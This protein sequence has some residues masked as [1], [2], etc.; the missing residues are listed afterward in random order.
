MR[1][2][3]LLP[4][5]ETHYPKRYEEIVAKS[6]ELGFDMQSD[7]GIGM[8]LRSLTASKLSGQFLELGTGLGLS[9][10]WMLDGMDR[11]SELITVESEESFAKVAQDLLGDDHRVTFKI[12]DGGKVISELV[13]NSFDLIFADTWPGKYSLLDETLA[14]LKI[15]GIYLIDD[16]LPQ[17]NWPDGHEEKVKALL[18]NLSSRSDLAVSVMEYSTGLLCCTKIKH[19][20]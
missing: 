19:S 11:S 12:E 3:E 13:E 5:C 18:A 14:L 2:K 1:V 10:A 20:S 17:E 4:F 7:D 15:G 16:M 6:K 8:L 9:T